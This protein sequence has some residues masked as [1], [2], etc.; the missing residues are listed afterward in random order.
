MRQQREGLLTPRQAWTAFPCS[1]THGATES[2]PICSSSSSHCFRIRV[3]TGIKRKLSPSL[4][5]L[6]PLVGGTT[7]ERETGCRFGCGVREAFWAVIGHCVIAGSVVPDL[8][9][10]ARGAC[11]HVRLRW[12]AGLFRTYNFPPSFIAFPKGVE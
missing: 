7:T 10:T 6:H 9:R 11:I 3:D 8:E 4:F 2:I 12:R 5:Q 1:G